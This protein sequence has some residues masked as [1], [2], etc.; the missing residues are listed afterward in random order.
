MTDLETKENVVYQNKKLNGFG[1]A[2][3]NISNVQLNSDRFN[4][5]VIRNGIELTT[6]ANVKKDDAEV[7][8]K[9]ITLVE[10]PAS[11]A[12]LVQQNRNVNYKLT[13]YHTED[14]SK[15]YDF[16]KIPDIPND[17]T[18]T[19]D[20][21]SNDAMKY[22]A[23]YT[24]PVDGQILYPEN[25]TLYIRAPFT[26]SCKYNFYFIGMDNK[27]FMMDAHDDDTTDNTSYIRAFYLRKDVKA[28]AVCGKY[29]ESYL[30]DSSLRLYTESKADYD[31]RMAALNA[32]PIT[33]VKYSADKFTFKTDFT[34]NKFIVS[35][36]A[37][38]AG[39]KVK[40]VDNVTKKTI[41][42]KTYNGN[43]G[44]VSFVAPKG[45][46]SYTMSYETPYL[47]IT[48]IVS[49]FAFIGF[50]TSML[51]YHLYQEKKRNHHLDQLFRE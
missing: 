44:F 12:S 11:T 45:S 7:I 50:F 43:G 10:T 9:D 14:Y 30:R 18:P 51:G 42:I 40:A 15:F 36:V 22:F 8:K 20:Y 5:T 38:D 39:W 16:A 46:Y 32:N 3:N 2:Y 19:T 26:G 48:Y 34:E 33:D 41:D 21:D 6:Y 35:Q 29:F 13:H 17:L 25:T 1:Q 27:I 47:R 23:F 24:S 37:F 31:Y 28:I 49:A 4:I